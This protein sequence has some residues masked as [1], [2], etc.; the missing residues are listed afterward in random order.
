MRP[1]AQSPGH[2]HFAALSGARAVTEHF[3][4][5][6]HQQGGRKK[7]NKSPEYHIATEIRRTQVL[8]LKSQKC[9]R[10]WGKKTL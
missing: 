2:S 4:N 1:L 7:Q 10:L 6:C 3:Y 9:E 8:A 5:P